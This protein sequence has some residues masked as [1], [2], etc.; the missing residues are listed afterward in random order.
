MSVITERQMMLLLFEE[1]IV[2]LQ[3]ATIVL[4]VKNYNVNPCKIIGLWGRISKQN[5]CGCFKESITISERG[6]QLGYVKTGSR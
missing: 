4:Y 2:W 1:L 3:H 6:R 5:V